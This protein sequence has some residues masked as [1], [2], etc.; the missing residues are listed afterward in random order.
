MPQGR[1]GVSYVFDIDGSENQCSCHG[2]D[3]IP[4]GRVQCDST[5]PELIDSVVTAHWAK[6]PATAHLG[7]SSSLA[8]L[9][10]IAAQSCP[11][12]SVS[13]PTPFGAGEWRGPACYCSPAMCKLRLSES[14]LWLWP[15]RRRSITLAAGLMSADP[16]STTG[17]RRRV[18]PVHLRS[19]TGAA[20]PLFRRARSSTF[21]AMC[22]SI[23]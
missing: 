22:I 19:T 15:L 8:L 17:Y 23:G 14:E 4:L 11:S 13:L 18:G 1:V 12:E 6:T 21:S 2:H 5:S 10:P 7:Q 16:R 20:A 3:S 9:A